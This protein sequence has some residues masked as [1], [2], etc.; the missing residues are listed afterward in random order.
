MLEAAA[1]GVGGA[2]AGT[3]AD[4]WPFLSLVSSQDGPLCAGALVAPRAVLT[5][6]ACAAG[7]LSGA[8]PL[9][10]TVGVFNSLLDP[11]R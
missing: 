6:A 10:A 3:L 2:D 8:K 7:L 4:R 11:F 5:T 1:L 9:V